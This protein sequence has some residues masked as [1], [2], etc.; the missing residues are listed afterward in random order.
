MGKVATVQI[1]D[2]TSIIALKKFSNSFQELR[3][4]RD[5]SSFFFFFFGRDE[6]DWEEKKMS[7]S[8]AKKNVRKGNN[9]KSF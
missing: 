7:L 8:F 1:R 6:S 2:R 5:Y 9:K 3:H 4:S